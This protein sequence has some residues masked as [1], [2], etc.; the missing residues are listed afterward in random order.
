MLDRNDPQIPTTTV[1][2]GN[3]DHYR[4]VMAEIIARA[5]QRAGIA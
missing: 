5:T 2:D 4:N 1:V 3:F